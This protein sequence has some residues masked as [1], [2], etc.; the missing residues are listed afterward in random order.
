MNRSVFPGIFTL[1]AGCTLTS[2]AEHQQFAIDP[3][4][5][6]SGRIDILG[7]FFF[8]LLG[9]I[10]IAVMIVLLVTLSRRH[11]GIEQEPLEGT[12]KPSEETDARVRR[13]VAGCTIAS[14][15]ILFVLIVAS[16]STGKGLSELSNK[17]NPLTIE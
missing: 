9:F 2:C 6:Q 15:V 4:G 7:W 17:K 5:P 13:V 12:H 16:V 11:G 10:F 8:W 3:A 1:I 14:V